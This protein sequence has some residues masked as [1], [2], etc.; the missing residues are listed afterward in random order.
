MYRLIIF[1]INLN[2]DAKYFSKWLRDNYTS[3]FKGL[4]IGSK[5]TI[6]FTIEPSSADK[7]TITDKYESLTADDVLVLENVIVVYEGRTE[8][9]QNCY[10][11]VRG[12]L[13]LEYNEGTLPITHASYIEHKL[14]TVKSFLLTGDWATAQYEMDN[15]VVTGGTVSQ[16]DI[17]N[18]F[19]Q[20]RYDSIKSKIDD[21][22]TAHY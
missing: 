22:V 19:T 15:N 6:Y 1:T 16:T 2:A 3:T 10:D 9:G 13:A 20:A 8:D 7:T 11:E 4:T 17:D 21:Y 12:N 18:G 5:V 14:I